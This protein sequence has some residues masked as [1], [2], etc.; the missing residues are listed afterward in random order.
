MATLRKLV[1]NFVN[2]NYP[3]HY[4]VLQPDP[5]QKIAYKDISRI[6]RS[7]NPWDKLDEVLN[8]MFAV[9]QWTIYQDLIQEFKEQTDPSELDDDERD[10]IGL[11]SDIQIEQL[12]TEMLE[13]I[14]NPFEWA[15]EQEVSVVITL[16]DGYSFLVYTTLQTA[17][18]IREWI[19]DNWCERCEGSEGEIRELAGEPIDYNNI[20]SIKPVNK[21]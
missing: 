21:I 14:Q 5:D 9:K 4:V 19:V 15:Y 1:E 12:L 20:E 2:K 11:V 8:K 17:M 16:K 10:D 7:R 3:D 13:D 6:V 18:S